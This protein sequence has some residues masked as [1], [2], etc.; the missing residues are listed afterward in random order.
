MK[1]FLEIYWL[2]L[3]MFLIC[4]VSLMSIF[5]YMFNKFIESIE[6]FKKK[7]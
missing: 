3:I 2:E 6:Y 7:K 4:S 1:D 5:R